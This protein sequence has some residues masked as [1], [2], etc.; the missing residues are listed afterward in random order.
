MLRQDEVLEGRL[1]QLEESTGRA[2]FDSKVRALKI[3]STE[4][5]LPTGEDGIEPIGRI[6]SLM[7]DLA[8]RMDG[9]ERKNRILMEGFRHREWRRRRGWAMIAAV[10]ALAGLIGSGIWIKGRLGP[11]SRPP[12]VVDERPDGAS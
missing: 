4:T 5:P 7:E 8:R 1:E 11:A 9:L 6:L 2:K 12:A 3:D 10:V